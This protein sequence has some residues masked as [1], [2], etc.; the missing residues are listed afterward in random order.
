[1]SKPR[2]GRGAPSRRRPRAGPRRPSTRLACGVTLKPQAAQRLQRL[3]LGLGE[4]R[5]ERAPGVGEEAQAAL[6]GD[7]RIDLAQRAGGGVARI[8]VGASGRPPRRRRSGRRSR[9][10]RNRPRRA[11]R[12]RPASPRRARRCGMSRDGPQVGGDVLADPAVAARRA[13]D[14]ARRSRSAARPRG[15]RSWARRCRRPAPRRAAGSGGR[16]RRTRAPRRRRRR[17]RAT[18][19]ARRA[20]PARTAA[21]RAA[22]TRSDGEFSRTR[23]G[24]RAS[25]SALRR[26]SAS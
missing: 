9:R 13:L 23:C 25:I 4:R 19:S 22:P 16:G 5:A 21:A 14:A 11:P 17:C 20:R 15:R 18:A 10:G 24:K 6:G 26:F 2:C 7:L 1:M 3:P 8:D 12:S